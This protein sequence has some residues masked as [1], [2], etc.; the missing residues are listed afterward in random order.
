[1]S[2]LSRT[3]YYKEAKTISSFALA[4]AEDKNKLN[5]ADKWSRISQIAIIALL[6]FSV[7]SIFTIFALAKNLKTKEEES[8]AFIAC[9]FTKIVF[10]GIYDQITKRSDN[11]VDDAN[12]VLSRLKKKETKIAKL[13]G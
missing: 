3:N 10:F 9:T 5:L 13:F 8:L 12:V 1:M 11:Y 4:S 7:I 2:C 6:N